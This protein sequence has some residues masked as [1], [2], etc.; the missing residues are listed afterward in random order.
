MDMDSDTVPKSIPGV[1]LRVIR[2]LEEENFPISWKLA[3]SWSGKTFLTVTHFPAES[4]N[5]ESPR[6]AVALFPKEQ[7]NAAHLEK[8]DP[9]SSASRKRKKKSPSQQKRDRDRWNRW[10][11]KHTYRP[12]TDIVHSVTV[13][14]DNNVRETTPVNLDSIGEALDVFTNC[15]PKT[16]PDVT[17]E[18][19]AC[20]DSNQNVSEEI[21][22]NSNMDNSEELDSDDS[23][24]D[25]SNLADF[26]ANCHSKPS[27]VKL[28]RCS[29]CQISQYC[30][31][32]C[33]RE[34]WKEHRVACSIVAKQRAATM[35]SN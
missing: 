13:A 14:Q 17:T 30:S 33:Q 28:K 12:S 21:G 6:K 34:N 19:A 11:Q 15:V 23:I 2:V 4:G 31:T 35:D 3:R 29:K 20:A 18:Q 5:K 25:F 9:S 10:R 27:G 24:L 16:D 7:E 22:L 26:C 1:F 8:T 32:Q